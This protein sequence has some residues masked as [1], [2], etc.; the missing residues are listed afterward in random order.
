MENISKATVF[1]NTGILQSE[2]LLKVK[3]NISFDSI[4][5]YLDS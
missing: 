4:L 5:L 3:P 2:E 1:P